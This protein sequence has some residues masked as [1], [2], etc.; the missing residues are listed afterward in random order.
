MK[1]EELRSVLNDLQDQL[2]GQYCTGWLVITEWMDSEGQRVLAARK[3]ESL[4]DWTAGGML[5]HVLYNGS[6]M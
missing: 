3:S 2:D 5:H 6:N 1:D 4:T